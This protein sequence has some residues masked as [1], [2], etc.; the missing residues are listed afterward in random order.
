MVRLDTLTHRRH[1]Q[2]LDSEA[3]VAVTTASDRFQ[4]IQPVSKDTAEQNN[5]IHTSPNLAAHDDLSRQVYCILGLAFDALEIPEAVSRIEAA[6]QGTAPFLI[7]TA[8]VNFLVSSQCDPQFRESLLLSDLCTADGMPIVWM[9]RL[10]GVPIRQR[11]AGSDV[12][13]VLKS[14]PRSAAPIRLFLFGGKEGLATSVADA[15]NQAHGRLHC[16]GSIYPGFGTVEDMSTDTVIEHINSSGA[17]FLVLSLGASKA[18]RWLMHNHDRLRIPVRTHFGAVL[19][20]EAGTVKRAPPL[21]AK[22]GFEWLWRI[23]EEPHLF[24]RYWRDGGALLRLLMTDVLPLAIW[25]R[26]QRSNSAIDDFAIGK[27]LNEGLVTFALHGYATEPHVGEAA[28]AFRGAISEDRN[29]KIDLNGTE[30]LDSRFFGLLLML[31]KQL[32]ASAK[33]LEFT[34]VSRRIGRLFHLNGVDFLLRT[35]QRA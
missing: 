13:A 5:T 32:N 20:F 33:R 14:A 6:A 17:N 3:A 31:R 25:A 34:G 11:V 23:K 12:F 22:L 8:N 7:S 27:T 16:V 1:S 15:I 21:W 24:T 29:V 10:L 4:A 28:S 26:R 9:A 35:G 18:H 19:N 30:F 2:A